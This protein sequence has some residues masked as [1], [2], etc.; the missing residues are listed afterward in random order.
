MK[1]HEHIYQRATMHVGVGLCKICGR[2]KQ[3]TKQWL[4][5]RLEQDADRVNVIGKALL[6]I[7]ERQTY[8]EQRSSSTRLD[9][10]VGFS[11]PDARIGSI[12]ARMFKAGTLHDEKNAWVIQV[13]MRAA[14]DGLPRVCKYAAQL[15]KIAQQKQDFENR[16]YKEL[17][18]TDTL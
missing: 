10:G 9:N 17:Q 14:K 15:D 7:Y 2:P 13:W 16:N 3:V 5:W 11:G 12:G 4:A 1:Q 8:D 18:F 6:A